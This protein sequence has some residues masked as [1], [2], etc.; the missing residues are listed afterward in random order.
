MPCEQTSK[1]AEMERAMNIEKHSGKNI[2]KEFMFIKFT[3]VE[4]LLVIV[5]IAILASMLIPALRGVREKG[6]SINCVNNMKQIGLAALSYVDSY[7]TFMPEAQAAGWDN[8][9]HTA[10]WWVTEIHPF[11]DNRV[12]LGTAAGTSKSLICTSPAGYEE[13]FELNGEKTSNYLWNIYLGHHSFY[14]SSPPQY[15]PKRITRCSNPSKAGILADGLAKSGPYGQTLFFEFGNLTGILQY[16]QLRHSNKSF[17]GLF[18]DGHSTNL[19][20]YKLSTRDLGLFG[21]FGRTGGYGLIW[22]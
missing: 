13:R 14:A 3:L 4:L 17:N 2:L 22:Q 11:I 6:I 7:D 8:N 9:A 18:A 5:I 19:N 16:V 10:N 20:P 1:R 21:N 15:C 12:W